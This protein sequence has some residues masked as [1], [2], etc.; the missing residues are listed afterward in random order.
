MD[1]TVPEQA[2]HLQ[3]DS[4]GPVPPGWSPC[5]QLWPG[6]QQLQRLKLLLVG[7]HCSCL[8]TRA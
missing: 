5:Q 7:L 8:Q 2:E 6:L 4:A 1:A 3:R